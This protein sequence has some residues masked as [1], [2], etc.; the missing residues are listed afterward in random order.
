MEAN[1][2]FLATCKL[3]N[4]LQEAIRQLSFSEKDED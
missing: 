4:F 2:S 3:T 1:E